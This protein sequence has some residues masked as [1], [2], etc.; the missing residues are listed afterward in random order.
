MTNHPRIHKMQPIHQTHTCLSNK[1]RT[2]TISVILS[3][4]CDP[5]YDCAH[6]SRT[7]HNQSSKPRQQADKELERKKSSLFAFC[8]CLFFKK[9]LWP[10]IVLFLSDA[11]TW[12]LPKEVDFQ[13]I[14]GASNW[15]RT[16]A[17]MQVTLRLHFQLSITAERRSRLSANHWQVSVSPLTAIIFHLL[18]PKHTETH[19]HSDLVRSYNNHTTRALH[20]CACVVQ[21][22]LVHISCS[23]HKCENWHVK[24]KFEAGGV[25]FWPWKLN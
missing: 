14:T 7:I 11:A 10:S 5:W 4:C 9:T 13:S 15:L 20:T 25:F 24:A 8:L 1:Q 2:L 12:C 17:E 21:L 18:V 16:C 3:R 6:M 23:F 22:E 19:F